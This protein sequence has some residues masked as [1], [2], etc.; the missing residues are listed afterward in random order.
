MAGALYRRGKVWWCRTD[1]V[2]G[3]RTS[4]QCT[5]R[6]AALTWLADRERL[7]ANPRDYA[8][9]Q[10]TFGDWAQRVADLKKT[11]RAAGTAD[12][13]RVKLGHALRLFGASMRMSELT[14][15]RVDWYIGVRQAEGASNNTIGK[16]LTAIVQVARHAARAG[17]FGGDQKTLKP[18]GFSID[19]TPRDR[20]LSD[21]EVTLL[22]VGM[23]EAR[24]AGVAFIL[25]TSARDSEMRRA[26]AADYDPRRR[27]MRLRGTKTERADREV[28]IP[29]WQTELFA[30]SVQHLPFSEAGIAS[31]LT[32]WCK[33]LG[34]RHAS[35]NDLRRTCATRLLARGVSFDVAAKVLG[36]S[37]TQML[38]RV[39]GKLSGDE[40]VRLVESQGGTETSQ[41]AVAPSGFEPERPH[42][43]R[44]LKAGARANGSKNDPDRG[45]NGPHSAARSPGLCTDPSHLETLRRRLEALALIDPLEAQAGLFLV[46]AA[47]AATRPGGSSTVHRLLEQVAETLGV[48]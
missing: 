35:P 14:P 31:S 4:T 18:I 30:E 2:T 21:G 10:A 11:T 42:G 13:Y 33:K 48:A 8:A 27:V 5:N 46:R 44:I 39:Y 6:R 16:E 32:Y 20:V 29:S 41:S 3:K 36:H 15:P 23:P 37:G 38:F 7:A 1:P 9:D 12:M 25:V 47:Q 22:R 34:L 45:H 17:E 19:Y 26:T 24:F 40:L 43:R 28:P